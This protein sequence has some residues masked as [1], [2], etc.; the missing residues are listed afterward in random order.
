[1]FRF[2]NLRVNSSVL[3]SAENFLPSL[4]LVFVPQSRI[5]P[6]K[7]TLRYYYAHKH[8]TV[9]SGQEA[10]D[11]WQCGFG[12]GTPGLS[13]TY[14]KMDSASKPALTILSLWWGRPVLTVSASPH[15]QVS[16]HPVYHIYS[17]LSV[18][19]FKRVTTYRYVDSKEPSCYRHL[20]KHNRRIYM[21]A[22]RAL[23]P[24]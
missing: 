21:H 12:A 17:F 8:L 24:E 9:A 15:W 5:P 23:S 10:C 18:T 16:C 6:H 7:R 22:P 11:T 20:V 1:M 19:I 4:T 3:T 13:F 14:Q 2:Q